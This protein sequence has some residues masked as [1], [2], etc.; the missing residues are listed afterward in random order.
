MHST[1]SPR[2][3]LRRGFRSPVVGLALACCV[4]AVCGL[5]ATRDVADAV[6]AVAGTPSAAPVVTQRNIVLV[7][8]DDFSMNLLPY[9]PGVQQLA[10][11][12]T[13]MS[14][15]VITGSQCCPS[16]SSMLTGRFPHDILFGNH[17]KGG[18]FRAFSGHGNQQQTFAVTLHKL[19]YNTAMMGRYL[20]GYS[21]TITVRGKTNYVPPGWSEWDVTG[22]GGNNG[23]GYTLN[24]NGRTQTFGSTSSSYLT[25]VLTSKAT[26]FVTTSAAAH[27]KF[28]LEVATFAPHPPY[29]PAPQ[30]KGKFADVRQPRSPAYDAVPTDAPLWL[31]TRAPLTR[32]EQTGIDADFRSRV[33][34]VQSVDRMLTTLRATLVKAGVA[35]NTVVVFTSD[36]GYHMGE[37]RLLP[38]T[39]TAFDTDVNV[40]LIVAGP[41][42]QANRTVAN[43]VENV[44]LAPT[45]ERL[46]GVEP[47]PTA[48][49]RSLVAL[50]AGAPTPD[51]RT[52][53]LIEHGGPGL[54]GP[55]AGD[56]PS[57]LALRT[58]DYT[59]VQYADGEREFY[60]RATDP[61]ELHN[62]INTL[63]PVQQTKLRNALSALENCHGAASCW[64]AGHVSP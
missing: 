39:A 46:A 9:M 64:T 50:L 52:A 51:W 49:G 44:D 4:A 1:S 24:V 60:N 15:Y 26:A 53:S 23:F 32:E 35:N 27:K 31:T 21:P 63:P 13:S 45:F 55:D 18:G 40:P 14:N 20:D 29:V 16:D 19:D 41:G 57:Y 34:D 37:Y 17:S 56:A 5:V 47:K 48:D 30:D 42:V 25:D 12:G 10:K 36:N 38:G 43:V 59:Y 11:D 61:Y 3:R 7:L 6:D 28:F 8:V 33:R 22:S 62:I 58:S 54:R 2:R